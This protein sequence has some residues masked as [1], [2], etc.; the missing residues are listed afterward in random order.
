MKWSAVA[1]NRLEAIVVFAL[2]S[3]ALEEGLTHRFECQLSV[4]Q[5]KSLATRLEEAADLDTTFCLAIFISLRRKLCSQPYNSHWLQSKRAKFSSENWSSIIFGW[6]EESWSS[7]GGRW[8]MSDGHEGRGRSYRDELKFDFILADPTR[9][10]LQ[11][12]FTSDRIEV[13]RQQDS[14]LRY[15]VWHHDD[16]TSW[17]VPTFEIVID[18][19]TY[20]MQSYTMQ[21]HFDA[22]DRVRLPYS[23]EAD[24]VEYG[25]EF[26]IPDEVRE[27]SL[28]L[29]NLEQ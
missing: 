9:M 10:L 7:A 14:L 27:N 4:E 18:A 20:V 21:W 3:E 11:Y 22:D 25:G 13:T 1:P 23:V 12:T 6:D 8:T 5:A 28:Y 16:S 19:E 17:P 26:E 29:A 2:E 24:V 15:T